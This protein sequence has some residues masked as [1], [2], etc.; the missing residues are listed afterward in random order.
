MKLLPFHPQEQLSPLQNLS[1]RSVNLDIEAIRQK[2]R[3]AIR[4]LK[5]VSSDSF[6]RNRT[7]AGRELPE[8]YLVYFLLVDLLGFEGL[9]RHE[10]I[11]WSVPVDLNGQ[12][13]FIEHRKLG[14]G[15]F[16][17]D[18]QDS[19]KEA[20]EVV[21]LIK[22]GIKTSQ[23]YLNWRAEMAVQESEVNVRNR[24]NDLYNRFQFLLDLYKSKRAE[25]EVATVSSGEFSFPDFEIF[26]R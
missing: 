18:D 13:L 9:G 4:P 10:K 7:K 1:L 19:E 23:P 21:Q 6:G 8:Y 25:S 20:S 16:S 12:I 15:V 2:A 11:A 3:A 5:T 24:S 14:L 22:R 17:S 26:I